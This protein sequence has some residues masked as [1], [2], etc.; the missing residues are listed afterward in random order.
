VLQKLKADPDADVTRSGALYKEFLNGRKDTEP[1]YKRFKMWVDAYRKGTPMVDANHLANISKLMGD[2]NSEFGEALRPQIV[3]AMKYAQSASWAKK[4]VNYVAYNG[5]IL[6]WKQDRINKLNGHYGLRMYS[7]SDFHP[8]FVLENMQMITD[9]AVRGLKM[10]G[11]TKDTDFVE[12]FAPTGMNINVSTFGFSSGGNVYEN[13]IIG[14]EWEK[15]KALREKH[16]NVGVT[17]VAT[18]DTLVEWALAQDWIDVVI[19][20]HLVRTGAEVAKAFGYTNYTSES[21]DTK[22][23]GWAKGKDKKYIAPTEHNND[24]ATYLAAL[25]KNHLKPRFERFL[26]NPNYMKLVNECRQSASESKPVQPVFDEDAAM[27]ALAKLE[28]NG[29]YQPIG[30]SVDRMYEIAAE[31]AEDMRKEIAPVMSLSGQ[32][33]TDDPFPLLWQVKGENVG[34]QEFP[35]PEGYIQEQADAGQENAFPLPPGV[36][37][38]AKTAEVLVHEDDGKQTFGDKLR[39]AWE[40]TKKTASTIMT[41]TNGAEYT[42]FASQRQ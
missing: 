29:Y 17:F 42:D 37:E 23:T 30:G 19:P 26:D 34:L 1:M 13:N 20:Y 27:R 31:V 2:I 28:A 11:Y 7:F 32:E 5:H 18:N 36:E 10:L 38:A 33:Q 15:A 4:R 12:I 24:K 41:K 40:G 16:P 9:A 39:G 14:A 25:E 35:L 21:A 3:D 6:K 8:A 22:D